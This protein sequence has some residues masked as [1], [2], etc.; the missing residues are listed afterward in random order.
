MAVRLDDILRNNVKDKLA[1]GEI[2]ASMIVRLV[3]GIEIARL[4]KTAGFDTIY[5]DLQHSSI[6]FDV[7]AQICMASLEMA[8]APFVRVPRNAP[9][10]IARVLDGGALGIIAPDVRSAGEAREVVAAAKFPPH[11][12]RGA[13]SQLPHLQFRHFP[14]AEA[15]QRLNEV[16]M[17]VVQFETAEAIERAE[18]IVSVDGVDMVLLGA[19]DLSADLGIPGQLEHELLRKAFARTIQVCRAHGKHVGL[20]GLASQ[21]RLIAEFV[22]MGARY[23]STG[24]DLSFLLRTATERATAA[25]ALQ[26]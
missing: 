6:P 11:G 25:H 19:N 16:T 17:V 18:E 22:E 12:D 4:A 5:V 24:T 20:G 21:P 14:A 9:E 7:A 15:R 8:M 13:T 1:R 26:P 23:V 2:V 10:Y 3:R